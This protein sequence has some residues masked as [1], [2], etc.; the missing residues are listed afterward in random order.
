M[1]YIECHA[2][3]VSTPEHTIDHWVYLYM[4]SLLAILDG[5]AELPAR[6][7]EAGRELISVGILFLCFCCRIIIVFVMVITATLR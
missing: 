3:K 6:I 5:E 4:V 7:A 2:E 1:V